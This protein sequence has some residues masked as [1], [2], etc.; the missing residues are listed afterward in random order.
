L[1]G[2][3]SSVE[4]EEDNNAQWDSHVTFTPIFQN[5]VSDFAKEFCG[6]NYHIKQDPNEKYLQFDNFCKGSYPVFKPKELAYEQLPYASQHALDVNPQLQ[7]TMPYFSFCRKTDL[8]TVRIL[9]QTNGH[10]AV[11]SS[12]SESTDPGQVGE[13]YLGYFSNFDADRSTVAVQDFA[14]LA[15]ALNSFRKSCQ[16]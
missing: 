10:Y 11:V 9:Q 1:V 4:S 5:T 8:S 12:R 14:D 15:S 13:F 16:N 3:F 7:G 2:I 6:K